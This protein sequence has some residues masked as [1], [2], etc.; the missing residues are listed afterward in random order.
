[1][2]DMDVD[3]LVALAL[4]AALTA[5]GT[6]PEATVRFELDGPVPRFADVPFPSELYRDA[7]GAIAFDAFPNP[8]ADSPMFN[9]LR[10]LLGARDGFCATCAIT[11][12]VDGEIA[13]ADA[14]DVTL[15]D[16]DTGE[17]IPVRR[18]WDHERN[19]LSVRPAHG[20]TLRGATRYAAYAT[21]DTI[22]AAPALVA[23]RDGEGRAG[24]VLAPAFASLEALGVPRTNIVGLAAFATED[25]SRDLR[26]L[27]D[28]VNAAP[29]PELTVDHIYV[30]DALD[31]LLGIPK[32][33]GPGVDHEPTTEG[34]RAVSHDTT[35]IV[36][37]GSFTAPRFVSG[38]GTDVGTST[39]PEFTTDEVPFVL[40]VPAG[41]DVTRLPVVI[42]QH[43]FNASRTTAFALADTAGRAGY[44]VLAIDAFQHG[45]RAFSA[46]DEVHA[47]RGDVPGPDG[48]AEATMLDVSSRMFGLAGGAPDMTLFPGY[49]LAAFE[50]FA[51]D[52][53]STLRVVREADVAPLRESHPSLADLR[54]DA[55]RIVYVGNSMGAV[56]GASV[57]AVEP[58]LPAVL[59][60]M[61]GSIVETLCESGEFRPLTESLLLP[62]I[63]VTRVFDE[64]Q[65]AMV[66][67]PTVDLFRWALEPIDPLALAPHLASHRGDRLVQLAGHDEV[68]APS[69]SESVVAAAGIEPTR[70]EGAM[71][72]MLEVQQQTSRLLPP[73]AP[74]FSPRP[75]PITIANPIDDVHHQIETFLHAASNR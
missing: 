47:M 9:A 7:S 50:Q 66:F 22:A 68:A 42:A 13:N 39:L 23:A 31:D 63:G 32:N 6:A 74:P 46:R 64:A 11:F 21:S 3:A 25:P 30:D 1:M 69:A 45:D 51:G 58:D 8:E 73:L 5:C 15:L 65:H 44:A 53:L 37:T 61:P 24:E 43:G 60:V 55:D 75:E 28:A 17:R 26:T 72:G 20:V 71:H 10:E 4:A 34:T 59:N 19:W 29:L 52:I 41:V 2:S 12:A 33:A 70:F 56:V 38:S 27:R 18:Q 14:L 35:A 16:L 57:L 36:V 67:D 62:Q 40:I 54:F 48:F 49:A